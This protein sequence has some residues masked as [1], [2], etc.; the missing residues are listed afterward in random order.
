MY[1]AIWGQAHT[2]NNQLNPI[3]IDK[4]IRLRVKSSLNGDVI[5]IRFFNRHDEKGY[6]L[7]QAKIKINNFEASLTFNGSNGFCLPINQEIYSDEIKVDIKQK[8]IIEISYFIEGQVTSG[9]SLIEDLAISLENKNLI[10]ED[11]YEIEKKT[12]RDY[13][14]DWELAIPAIEEIAINTKQKERVIVLFGDS[15]SQKCKYSKPLQELFIKDN[16][17]VSIIN[18]AINGNMFLSDFITP[19]YEMDGKAGV[20]RYKHDIFETN[21]VTDVIFE[22]GT[23]DIAI[24]YD[25]AKDLDNFFNKL[26]ELI[27]CAKAK[28]INVYVAT[29]FPRS[30][31]EFNEEMQETRIAYNNRIIENYNHIDIRPAMS[32]EDLN[33]LDEKTALEDKLHPNDFGGKR[34]AE[35]IYK[36][37]NNI[38]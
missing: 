21:G 2:D 29:I 7:S 34:I 18:K 28:N 15:I 38:G 25:V 16:K 35:L 30:D 37:L 31:L 13:E 36:R 4:T 20:T 9:N 26:D 3:M 19:G 10:N 27:E 1:Q 14:W 33:I 11:T 5:K 32:K 23:N 24:N 6:T 8:D 17:Q 22:L 12:T